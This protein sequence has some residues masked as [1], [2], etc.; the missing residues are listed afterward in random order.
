VR[1]G[2]EAAATALFAFAVAAA[3][4]V[5]SLSY[6]YP[7]FG[8][9]WTAARHA[10]DPQLYNSA[11][12]TAAQTWWPGGGP[13]PFIYPPTFLLL[14]WP[15]G[16]LP[17][18]P[19]YCVWNGLSCAAFIL[20][21]RQVVKPAWA[22]AL[23]PLCVP[24]ALAA[25]YGQSVFFAGAA[26]IT[27]LAQIER[28]PRLAGVL[29][30]LAVCIKPQLTIL[31]PLALIGS[32]WRAWAAALATVL[33]AVAASLVFGPRHWLE[34][35]AALPEFTAMTHKMQLKFVNLL[36]PGL[37]APEKVMVVA[38]GVGFALWSLRRDLPDRIVGVVCGSLCCALY[39]VRCDLAI[40]APSGLAWVLG[41]YSTSAW[42]RRI[43]GLL[44]IVG[45]V[46]SSLGVALLML[47]VIAANWVR[48][49]L[50]HGG[51]RFG[52]SDGAPKT[53]GPGLGVGLGQ[54]DG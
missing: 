53:L 36:A 45:L 50:Q 11:H 27:A 40:L 24:V 35:L 51:A 23:L 9:F 14:A 25:A 52:A 10:Y 28:R 54:A 2:V 12:L 15:F 41:G 20:A 38:A 47:V 5:W 42:L 21:A 44:L 19:A 8:V 6:Q 4:A 22:A 43:A 31:A 30:A 26:L 33:L 17:V 32:N 49:R 7:D 34:W 29:I 13:H 37:P 46:D 39:A 1:Q 16:L 48:T 3:L 18:V